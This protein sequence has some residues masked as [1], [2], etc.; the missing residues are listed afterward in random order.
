MGRTRT[1]AT[2][3]IVLDTGALIALDRGDKRMIAL[4]DR[5]LTHGRTFRVPVG[6]VG[7]AW[8]DG[9]VQVTLARFLRSDAVE[10]VPLDEQ[11]AR[12]C[13]ELCGVTGT[14]DMIDASLAI[15]ARTR[16]EPI[17]TSD[18]EDLRRLDPGAQILAL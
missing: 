18:P 16:R 17:V 7:Q 15:L 9:R 2:P 13:G 6:V 5:A 12:A 14:A 4:L 3:G 8:R 11:L 10:I 1:R